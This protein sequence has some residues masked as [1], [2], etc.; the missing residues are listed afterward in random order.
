MMNESLVSE[1]EAKQRNINNML[2]GQMHA[3]NT[4]AQ[5][6]LGQAAA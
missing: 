2:Q 4:S 3:S 5:T 1:L 6:I